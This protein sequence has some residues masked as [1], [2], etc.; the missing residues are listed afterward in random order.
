[1]LL[2]SGPNTPLNRAL[3]ISKRH[4][5]LADGGGVWEASVTTDATI[6]RVALVERV[7][8]ADL[9]EALVSG[10]SQQNV[11]VVVPNAAD[12]DAYVR[13][14]ADDPALIHPD[15]RVRGLVQWLLRAGLRLRAVVVRPED[16]LDGRA[17]LGFYG[18]REQIEKL[19]DA[20]RELM[21][22]EQMP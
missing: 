22:R 14:L 12:L 2:N 1:V 5:H 9:N 21:A 16:G 3:S 7:D 6:R 4:P 10:G 19:R 20:T 15:F 11:F 8:K 17:G 13:A 18:R